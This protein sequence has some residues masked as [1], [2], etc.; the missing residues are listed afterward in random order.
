MLSPCPQSQTNEQRSTRDP[1][2]L[3]SAPLDLVSIRLHTLPCVSKTKTVLCFRISGLSNKQQDAAAAAAMDTAWLMVTQQTVTYFSDRNQNMLF[4][5]TWT[6]WS[7]NLLDQELIAYGNSSSCSS[8]SSWGDRLQKSQRLRRF[9]SYW[10][11]I[12]QIGRI[13]LQANTHPL[14]ESDFWHDVIVSKWR[15]WRHFTHQCCHLVSA[16]VVS[17]RHP[18]TAG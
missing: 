4:K 3:W 15:P 16:P 9:K 14:T 1:W 6:S 8:S 10:D 12:W 7:L 17:S 5:A 13:V 2:L 11:E 18:P